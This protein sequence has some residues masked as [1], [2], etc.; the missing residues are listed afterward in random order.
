MNKTPR[1][2]IKYR[3]NEPPYIEIWY[4]D[5]LVIAGWVHEEPFPSY[6]FD[7]DD[8][9]EFDDDDEFDD[10]DE[11]YEDE[12]EYEE[13]YED[14]DPFVPIVLG[15]EKIIDPPMTNKAKL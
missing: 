13:E 12:E 3:D 8:E 14:D 15:P 4:S 2:T 1:V 9:E 10:E 5:N 6:E 11:E 7:D